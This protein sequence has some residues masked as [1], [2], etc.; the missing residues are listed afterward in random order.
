[1]ITKP[2]ADNINIINKKYSLIQAARTNL[3][4]T[5][6]STIILNVCN[7][8]NTFGA[9]FNKT[10]AQEFPLAKE[11]YHLLGA[12]VIK[13][14]LGYTQFVPVAIN[15]KYRNQIIVANLICQT[16]IMSD[17]NPRPFNY[18]YFGS[19]LS[20]VQEYIKEYKNNHDLDVVVY[21]PKISYSITG[22]NWAFV[23]EMMLDVLKRPTYTIVYE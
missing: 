16:G 18:Y 14:K 13:S 5:N 2:V 21:S 4:Q 19:C 9:G 11:N 7:N 10:I 8:M 15:N 22:A 23:Y 6:Q 12:S 17:A 1:M 20:K 3:A